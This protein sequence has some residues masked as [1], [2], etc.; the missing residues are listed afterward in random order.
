[1]NGC[2][3]IQCWGKPCDGQASH[4]RG[5]RNTQQSLHAKETGIS[6][7]SHTDGPLGLYTDLT[8]FSFSFFRQDVILSHLLER[9]LNNQIYTYIGDI[10]I[11]VNPLKT[12]NLYGVEVSLRIFLHGINYYTC[13]FLLSFQGWWRGSLMVSVLDSGSNGLGSRPGQGTAL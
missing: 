9:Y 1:M 11:A 10:L 2:K 12:L 5:I 3:Q 13:K 7:A 4:P 6:S 8:F